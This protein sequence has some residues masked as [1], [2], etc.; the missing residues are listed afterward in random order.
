VIR[1]LAPRHGDAVAGEDRLGLV[2]VDLH[3]RGGL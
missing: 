1:Y 3:G 2:L